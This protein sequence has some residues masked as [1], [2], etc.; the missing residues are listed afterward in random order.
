MKKAFSITSKDLTFNWTGVLPDLVIFL[1]PLILLAPLWLMGK[2]MFWGTISLQFVPWRAYAW[3]MLRAGHL[4]LWNPLNGM[5]APLLANYQSALF[6]PPN[7]LLFVLQAIG[8]VEWAAWGQALLVG[9][10]LTWAGLGNARLVRRLGLGLLAQAIG[11]LAYGLSTYLVSRASFLSLINA[12]AWLPWI[13]LGVSNLHSDLMGRGRW[14]RGNIRPVL[15]LTIVLAMQLLAGHAQTVWFTWLLAFLWCGVW[16][17]FSTGHKSRVKAALSCLSWL[18]LALILAVMLAAVQLIPTAEFLRESQRSNQVDYDFAMSYS[19]WPWRFLTLLA[20]NLFGN[21]AQGDYWGYGNYWEDAVYIGLLP[22][23]M[24]ASG[25]IRWMTRTKRGFR[26]KGY[27]P[28]TEK[29]I[30]PFLFIITVVS[31]VFA[32]GKNTPIYPWLYRNVPGFNMFQAPT[33]FTLWGVLALALLAGYGV[34]YWKRPV[35]K[36]LY[37]V[38]LATAGACAI[39]LGAGLT[40]FLFKQVNPTL[41]KATAWVGVWGAGVGA[42]T[43]LAPVTASRLGQDRP[44]GD[45]KAR[46][47]SLW[48]LGVL[49]FVAADLLWANWGLN[50]AVERRFYRVKSSLASL[51][52]SLEGRLYL[53]GKDEYRLKFER[54]MRFDTFNPGEEWINLREAMLPNLNLLDGLA[55]ANNFDPL[56]PARYARWMNALEQVNDKDFLRK[57]LILMG[58]NYVESIDP[59]S[60]SGVRFERIGTV[61]PFRWLPCARF[62]ENPDQAWEIVF[63]GKVDFEREVVLEGYAGDWPDFMCNNTPFTTDLLVRA[64]DPQRLHVHL[65]ARGEGWFVWSEVWYPGWRA[66]VDGEEVPILRANY[67]FRAVRVN[68]GVH[69]VLFVYRPMSFYWGAIISIISMVLIGIAWIGSRDS[70]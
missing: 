36:A 33:R 18:S 17:W 16:G 54:F 48:A 66:Y 57:L 67:L 28:W 24:A 62:A 35:G 6:Y 38:R 32:L 58:V 15:A 7:W 25:L 69:E 51:N 49:S 34:E 14:H 37:W 10:H 63:S 21:P 52:S 3:E 12:A 44:S 64:R 70:T 19:F 43:L 13:V 30:T 22:L 42:L 50:P 41:L 47:P 59:T 65:S 4:P 23:V 61:S 53:T 46:L 40:G 11:G 55:S 9:A 56:L 8:G 20:P 27:S 39:S 31:F 5:G 26:E 68:A 1:V 2:A 29:L 45:E 60:P